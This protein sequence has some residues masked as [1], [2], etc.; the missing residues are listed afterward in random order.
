MRVIG[1]AG[2]VDHGKSTLVEALT[3]THPDRLKEERERE[4]T[5]DLG[6]AW[7]SLPD[8]EE[9]GII[10]VPGHRD[11][12]ENMLAGVAW[13]DAAL[14]VIAADEGVMPQTRE[15]LAILDLLQIQAGVVAL[16][17]V[18]LVDDPDWLDLVSEDVRQV[19]S[20]S[21]LS[22]A[23]IVR[24]SARTQEGLPQLI[25]VLGDFLAERPPRLDVHRPR[26][27]IDRV[28]TVA[29]FG[30]IV[31][32]TLSDG[33]LRVG[34]EVEI[35]PN[36]L[37]GRVRGLQTHK[38]KEEVAVPGSRTAVNVAGINVDQL[39]RG[40]VIAHPGDYHPT[41]RLDVNFR[42]L[43]GASQALTHNTEVKLFLGAAELLA[44]VRLLG[45][46]ILE[47]G[48][49]GWLQ[50]ELREPVAAIRG[51]RYI[52]RR[53][54]PGETLGGGIV[55]DPHPKGRHKRFAD[56]LIASME[57][58]TRGAPEEVLL[59]ALIALGAA[60]LR[61]VVA[62][63]SLNAGVATQA[64]L[65]LAGSGQLLALEDRE[66]ALSIESEALVT[67]QA[68][69][70]QLS[71]RLLEE[72]GNYHK[73][74]P[75]RRGMPREEL[76]SRLRFN[77]RVFTA[78]F[79]QLVTQGVLEE[80]GPLVLRPGHKISFTLQQEHS[81][82][83]LSARFAAAPFNPPSVKEVQAELGEE[84]YAG[85]IE[86]GLLMPVSAEVVFRREDYDRMVAE[87]RKLI[88]QY[89]SVT[90]AQV[91]DHFNTSRR[92]VLALLEHLDAIGVTMRQGDVRRLKSNR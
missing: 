10:D 43:P 71:R 78:A 67:S 80:A 77:V 38:R 68:Y 42:L 17:K 32:G 86:D 7:M 92:Y 65:D 47:P 2:H 74:Y 30:T 13:I 35:L 79:R 83:V 82:Q 41:R 89:G 33:Q 53:P 23:P 51:D 55:V 76:K 75:L 28:F 14:F 27:P 69:W 36:R 81:A 9:I 88:E 18:D 21:V 61:E 58:L 44:R 39:K 15:H 40:D 22:D 8:G 45:Q 20:G 12:I 63:S 64:V 4:M 34:D 56:G 54:S 91:R 52:V 6:F 87:V 85:L 70:E 25:Q 73:A 1:T 48:E 11:F 5:I 57:A 62:R 3:G 90:A 49:E 24:V 16:T 66:N 37:R 19:L 29:G 84:L 50:L 31:T 26:L 72:V 46:E 59:Q 60:P